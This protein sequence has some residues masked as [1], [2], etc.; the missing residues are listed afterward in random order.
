MYYITQLM[1]N[2]VTTF[3]Q[4]KYRKSFTL[5]DMQPIGLYIVRNVMCKLSLCLSV[6]LSFTRH[7]SVLYRKG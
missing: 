2:F 1:N 3:A 6:R 5:D 7:T 4:L